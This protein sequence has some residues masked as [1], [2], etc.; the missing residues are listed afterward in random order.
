MPPSTAANASQCAE[1]QFAHLSSQQNMMHENMHQIISQV[2]A[3]SFNQSNAGHGHVASNNFDRNGRCRYG[4]GQRP[5]K[6][7]NNAFNGG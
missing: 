6:A 3:L 1:Q 2:N 5:R 7:C 4:H